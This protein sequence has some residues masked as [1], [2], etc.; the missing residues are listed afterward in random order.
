MQIDIIDIISFM[1][2]IQ[3][4]LEFDDMLI[5]DHTL[6]LWSD[7]S[8]NLKWH[9]LE[10]ASWLNWADVTTKFVI[11]WFYLIIYACFI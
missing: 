2:F 11:A 7:M 8:K 4:F 1:I 3:K 5:M 6:D 9:N 10:M